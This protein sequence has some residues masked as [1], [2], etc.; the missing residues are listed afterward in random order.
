M[1]ISFTS[2]FV[3]LRCLTTSDFVVNLQCYSRP[4]P[5]A[6][7][8]TLPTM[9]LTTHDKRPQT[10]YSPWICVNFCFFFFFFFFFFFSFRFLFCLLFLLFRSKGGLLCFGSLHSIN[11]H[12]NITF[13][14]IS[15][16]SLWISRRQA[17]PGFRRYANEVWNHFFALI[18]FTRWSW[19]LNWIIV[20]I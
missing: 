17:K 14:V 15:N 19:P 1:S 18:V 7:T 5:Q 11:N 16:I 6:T 9:P 4:L 20:Y 2:Y 3:L 12:F 8:F 13:D 10:S